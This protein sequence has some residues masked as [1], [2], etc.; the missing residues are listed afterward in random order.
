MSAIRG[1]LRQQ[2]IDN[3][4]AGN[5]DPEVEVIPTRV[6]GKYI[7]KHRTQVQS[8]P[9][10]VQPSQDPSKVKDNNPVQKQ[11]PKVEAESGPAMLE[12]EQER[13]SPSSSSDSE[14]EED[15]HASICSGL[16]LVLQQL[17]RMA[18]AQEQAQAEAHARA[19]KK[20]KKKKLKAMV[21]EQVRQL[22]GFG[23]TPWGGGPSLPPGVG[24]KLVN[25]NSSSPGVRVRRRL[26]LLDRR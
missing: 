20:E 23:F 17:Q 3:W 9:V 25:S 10:E 15:S 21:Q 14:E 1:K 11:P 7:V 4:L 16:G 12:Q 5:E 2:Y 6:E 8:D 19:Q 13:S 18:Q 22:G 26:N 24:A